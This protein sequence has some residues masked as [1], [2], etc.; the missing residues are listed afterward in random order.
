M[1]IERVKVE[2]GVMKVVGMEIGKIEEK[3]RLQLKNKER[4]GVKV[5]KV[6]E[7]GKN[8][9]DFGEKL[10]VLSEV[11]MEVLEREGSVRERGS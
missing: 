6:S 10:N 3:K 5:K 4:C 11:V 9:M 2:N 8:L 7:K 1:K